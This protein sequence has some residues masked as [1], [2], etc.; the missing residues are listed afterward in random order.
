MDELQQINQKL[1]MIPGI[2]DDLEK[3]RKRV[4]GDEEMKQPGLIDQVEGHHEYIQ[5]HKKKQA[6]AEGVRMAAA[7]L[8]S[9]LVAG[10]KDLWNLLTE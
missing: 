3:L 4:V 1:D 6:K 8:I 7:G 2:K 10:A 9:F 5:K